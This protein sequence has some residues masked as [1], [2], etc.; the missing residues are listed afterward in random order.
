MF[1]GVFAG[2]G[3]NVSNGIAE[4]VNV[5]IGV[6]VSVADKLVDVFTDTGE[7]EV[8]V[9]PVLLK[10]Q[11]SVADIKIMGRINFWFFMS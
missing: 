11:A 2:I 5:G 9:C 8:G 7:A 3:V 6:K 1:V 10:L 4:A